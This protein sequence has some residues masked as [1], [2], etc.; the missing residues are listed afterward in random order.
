MPEQATPKSV[1][2]SNRHACA[3]SHRSTQG[4]QHLVPLMSGAAPRRQRV[5]QL[6]D[7]KSRPSLP[8][9]STTTNR[10]SRSMLDMLGSL[11]AQ[12]RR[13]LR[14]KS[15]SQP[16]CSGSVSR[17]TLAGTS[18]SSSPLLHAS[19]AA[20][21][22]AAASRAPAPWIFVCDTSATGSLKRHL[23]LIPFTSTFVMVTPRQCSF[24]E[25]ALGARTHTDARPLNVR[26]ATSIVRAHLIATQSASQ[27][28]GCAMVVACALP[29]TRCS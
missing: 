22:H 14:A 11:V 23:V 8:S 17:W 20:L 29:A 3:T 1:V 5:M 12:L 13:A 19:S 15:S 16:S 6:L 25:D 26:S 2:I 7:V 10:S 27:A 4:H 9:Y 18:I 24:N 28:V 21:N